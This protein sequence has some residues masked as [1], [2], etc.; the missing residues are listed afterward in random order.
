[1]IYSYFLE[2]LIL[3][4]PGANKTKIWIL[5]GSRKDQFI[6]IQLKIILW[7]MFLMIFMSRLLECALMKV[8]IIVMVFNFL[9]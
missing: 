6:N 4:K 7:L 8:L 5:S 1:M 3:I 9:I 2:Y